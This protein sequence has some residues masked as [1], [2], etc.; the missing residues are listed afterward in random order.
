MTGTLTLIRYNGTEKHALAGSKAYATRNQVN[1]RPQIML[2]FE[3]ETEPEPLQS[4]P[5]SDE[6]LN[7]PDA[8]LTIYLDTLKLDVFAPLE[9]TI[10]Q[11]YNENS[12]SLD[13]RLYYFEHQEVNDNRGRIEYR[14]NSV[15]YV[16]WKGTTMDVNYYDGSKPDTRLELEGEFTM[17]KYEDWL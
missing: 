1:E 3:T 4:L 11:G 16:Y 5:D 7:N 6:L 12:R 2:W 8:E 13:A 10:A 15:F 14:G 9:F 17:E